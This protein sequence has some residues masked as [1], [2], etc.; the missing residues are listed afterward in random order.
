MSWFSP[1]MNFGG[2]TEPALAL[3]NPALTATTFMRLR[4][5]TRTERCGR[6]ARWC[7]CSGSSDEK[8]PMKHRLHSLLLVV[9]VAGAPLVT[10][11]Q[12]VERTLQPEV[13]QQL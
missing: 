6:W 7:G 9:F 8:P 4:L 1:A 3:D 5:S 12:A 11:A 13:Y 2:G 10:S